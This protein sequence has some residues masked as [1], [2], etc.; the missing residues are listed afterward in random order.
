[1]VDP[2]RPELTARYRHSEDLAWAAR[3][4]LARESARSSSG[5]RG[6]PRTAAASFLAAFRRLLGQLGHGRRGCQPGESAASTL[7]LKAGGREVEQVPRSR[8]A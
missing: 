7:S 8:A 2:F 1:M 4:R 6:L 5:R 3:E